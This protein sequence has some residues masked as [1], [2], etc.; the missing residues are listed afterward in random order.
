MTEKD[1]VMPTLYLRNLIT[2]VLGGGN[3]LENGAYLARPY[4]GF[5]YIDLHKQKGITDDRFTELTSGAL[6]YGNPKA[7]SPAAIA[8]IHNADVILQIN[9]E[10]VNGRRNL[11]ELI[12][13][14]GPESAL[15]V[16]VLSNGEEKVFRVV[17]DKLEVK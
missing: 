11:S 4:L 2:Q 17:L 15:D 12:W 8:G 5:D 3:D 13:Q 16:K 14:Y 6:V 1:I 7:S 9:G 10:N